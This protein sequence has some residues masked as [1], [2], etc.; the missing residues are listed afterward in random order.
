M[1]NTSLKRIAAAFYL[2][3]FILIATVT[4][5]RADATDD[6]VRSQMQKKRI[7]GLSLAVIRNGRVVKEAAYGKASLELNVPVTP[8]TSFPLASMTK[9]FT[10][11]AI[12]QLVEEGK[13]SLDEP[14]SQILSE[15][16]TPW[17]AI[18]IRHC[19]SHTSG[20]PDVLTDDVNATTVSGD[21]DTALAEV[22]KQPLKPAGAASVYNQTG[23]VLLGMIIEK[24]SG[25]SYET[26]VQSRVL[27]PAGMKTARFGDAWAIIPGQADLYTNLDITPDHTKLLMRDGRPVVLTDRILR[28]GSKYM[29]LSCA[30]GTVE[31]QSPRSGELGGNTGAREAIENLEPH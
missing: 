2:A 24:V 10:A 28:Y 29:P 17:S 7:P 13:I 30:G 6:Y 20:L 3:P 19:L 9:I 15:L 21:R 22:A 27:N 4:V 16:P 18:T 5:T 23:Y 8:D 31:R 14:V 1:P 11:T 12:M 26:F 25:M